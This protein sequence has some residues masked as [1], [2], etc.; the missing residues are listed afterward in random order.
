MSATG[1]RTG[2]HTTTYS[3]IIYVTRKVQ[4][5][6]LA[7]LDTYGYFSEDV[8]RKV[9]S[10]IRVLLDEEVIDQLQFTWRQPGSKR[11]LE[12]LRYAVILGVAV[13]MDDRS[14]GIQYRPELA[15]ADFVVQVRYNQRWL[16]IGSVGRD[17][18]RKDLKCP[19]GDGYYLDYSGGQWVTDRTYSS[20]GYGLVRQRFI[21]RN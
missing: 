20:G 16:S 21:R 13:L 17:T 18:V 9:V 8:A 11:V 7:I 6:F 1:T 10:D 4:A 19:W 15:A 14:G 2:T 3:K 5:D 12:E